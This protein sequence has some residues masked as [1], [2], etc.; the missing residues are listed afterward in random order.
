MIRLLFTILVL[1]SI[2]SK[3]FAFEDETVLYYNPKLNKVDHNEHMEF[4]YSKLDSL[5]SS[6]KQNSV[7]FV[8]GK[9]KVNIVH[10]GDSHIQADYLSGQ[11][12]KRFQGD[13]GNGGRGFVFPYQI[14]R[15]NGPSDIDVS[16]NGNWYAKSIFKDFEGSRI[17]ASGFVLTCDDSSQVVF[18]LKNT[19]SPYYGFNKIT[20]FERNGIYYPEPNSVF[21]VM[22]GVK[23]TDRMNYSRFLLRKNY[24]SLTLIASTKNSAELHG[25]VLENEYPG[26][27]YHAMGT[28]GASTLQFL[29]STDFEYQIAELNADL[30]ILSFGTNDSY[31]PGSRFCSSC[32]KERYRKIIR[33]IR[34]ESPETSILITTPPDSYYRR[35]YDNN[36]LKYFRSAMYELAKEQ[37][38]AVWDLYSV[39]GGA[40]SIMTWHRGGLARG[41]LIHFS[42]E[43]YRL[44]G[45]LLYEAILKGY[46]ERFD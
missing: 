9:R 21:V 40:R 45:D 1:I 4:F 12:R 23:S 41:D 15:S 46:E 14:A 27:L 43:G 42:K 19:V 11:T 3:D 2:A 36:N 10:I 6:V 24:D 44:Q 38:V 22:S 29:R 30:V 26:V 35:R 13:F 7:V 28:N 16:F 37:K 33:R 34:A 20:I 32:I 31:L 39:M 8:R 25:V 5:V 17:G 18:N